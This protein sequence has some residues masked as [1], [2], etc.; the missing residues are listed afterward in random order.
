MSYVLIAQRATPPVPIAARIRAWG[1]GEVRCNLAKSSLSTKFPDTLQ[2]PSTGPAYLEAWSLNSE[3]IIHKPF[4]TGFP[5]F[6]DLPIELRLAIWAFAALDV[7][8]RII[9]LSCG[10]SDSQSDSPSA[11]KFSSSSPYPILATVCT[12]ARRAVYQTLSNL[13]PSSLDSGE[14][15]ILADH[16]KDILLLASNFSHTQLRILGEKLG[17][18][19]EEIFAV[20]LEHGIQND[21]ILSV[22]GRTPVFI[23]EDTQLFHTFPSLESLVLVVVGERDPVSKREAFSLRATRNAALKFKTADTCRHRQERVGTSRASTAW[24]WKRG[25]LYN[26]L[27]NAGTPRD[28]ALS[29]VHRS[30]MHLR[31]LANEGDI[32]SSIYFSTE[33]IWISVMV[34]L[35]GFLFYLII[36]QPGVKTIRTGP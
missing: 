35:I 5:R 21:A 36:Y 33:A 22:E 23:P 28:R 30:R 26:E 8:G 34:E 10:L 14:Q 31:H 25:A 24:L 3:R 11:W 13:W 19:K 17:S 32:E 12:E 27:T 20:A 9:P 7:P 4:L 29:I 6:G 15:T 18:T 16:R 1:R 2:I